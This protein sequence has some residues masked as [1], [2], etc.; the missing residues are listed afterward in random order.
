MDLQLPLELGEF[1][2]EGGD[3]GLAPID[4]PLYK[5][6][7]Q[8][9]DRWSPEQLDEVVTIYLD[10]IIFRCGDRL[11]LVGNI[12]KLFIKRKTAQYL[13]DLD[14]TSV[15]EIVSFAARSIETIDKTRLVDRCVG[16][17]HI[18]LCTSV[19]RGFWHCMWQAIEQS[20][21]ENHLG[22]R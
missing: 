7:I 3:E 1:L 21:Q 18:H 10:R 12:D 4:R 5:H 22:S 19:F 8:T 11:N 20:R 16:P 2:A 6:P 15:E 9:R 14:S 13:L 17:E